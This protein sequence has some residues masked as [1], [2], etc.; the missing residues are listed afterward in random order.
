MVSGGMEGSV[1]LAGVE[2]PLPAGDAAAGGGGKALRPRV[3]GKPSM[4]VL[5]ILNG[6]RFV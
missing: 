3:W 5:K 2:M 4:K 1:G 6:S